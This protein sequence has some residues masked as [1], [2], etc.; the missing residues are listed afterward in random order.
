M[1]TLGMPSQTRNMAPNHTEIEDVETQKTRIGAS[2]R[3]REDYR[4]PQLRGCVGTIQ[5]IYGHNHLAV[6]VRFEDGRSELL[7]LHQ[8]ERVEEP[9]YRRSWR[10]WFSGSR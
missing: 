9:H 1:C 5:R 4:K 6:E 8:L 2:V 10:R 7:G 3:V